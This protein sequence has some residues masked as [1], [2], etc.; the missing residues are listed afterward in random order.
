MRPTGVACQNFL[1]AEVHVKEEVYTWVL[2]MCG[3]WGL[4]VISLLPD[5]FQNEFKTTVDS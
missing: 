1:S 4:Y 5:Q 3:E 2:I